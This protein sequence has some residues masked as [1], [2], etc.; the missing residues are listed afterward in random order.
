MAHK[1]IKERNFAMY[2]NIRVAQILISIKRID[3]MRK[4]ICIIN[5]MNFSTPFLNSEL[6]I[7]YYYSSVLGLNNRSV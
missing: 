7:K 4:F 6:V 5:I 2:I 1:D 3:G